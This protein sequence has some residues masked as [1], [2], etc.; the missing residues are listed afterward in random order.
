MAGLHL[1]L[2]IFVDTLINLLELCCGLLSGSH[3]DLLLLPLPGLL[4]RAKRE[5]FPSIHT[6]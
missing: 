4:D 3:V 1:E 5:K 2:Q 6:S